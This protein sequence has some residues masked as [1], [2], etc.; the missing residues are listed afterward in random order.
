MVR[1]AHCAQFVN[2]A[3]KA[4]GT[5]LNVDD[6]WSNALV[7]SYYKNHMSFLMNHPNK[8]ANGLQFKV[9]APPC[10]IRVRLLLSE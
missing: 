7:K 6:F 1:R 8:L 9:P 5:N 2:F 4:S 10:R 3:N